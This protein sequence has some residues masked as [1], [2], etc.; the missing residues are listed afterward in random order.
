MCDGGCNQ[1]ESDVCKARGEMRC[2][3]E[4]VRKWGNAQRRQNTVG[5]NKRAVI[6]YGRRQKEKK[7]V[8]MVPFGFPVVP[9]V[10]ITYA[11]SLGWQ[12]VSH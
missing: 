3:R 9:E 10:K 4:R 1:R 7:S 8:P 11:A 12:S 6:I 5:A 2:L